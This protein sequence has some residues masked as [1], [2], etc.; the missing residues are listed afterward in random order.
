MDIARFSIDKPVN[1]WLM[2]VIL[3]LGGI[4][5]MTEIGRLEDPAF[6]IKQVKVFTAYPGAGAQKVER[7]ITEPLEIAIQQM[8]QLKKLKSTSSPGKSEIT[9]EVKSNFDSNELPQIWDELRKRLRDVATS[10]PAGS[11]DPVVFD[12]FGDVYGLYYALSAPDFDTRELR[13]FARVIRRELLTTQG[14]A[15]VTVTGVQKERIVAYINP[16]QLAGLGISF[17]DLAQLFQDNLRPFNGGRIKI[18][19]KNVRLIVERAPDRLEEISNLSLV[20]PGTNRSLRVADVATLK[21]EPADI[22]PVLIRYNGS[23]ALTLAVSALSDVNIVDVGNRVNAK[24]NA[25]LETLP[26]GIELTPIYDQASVVD[27]SV[28]GFIANLVM[29]VAVVTLTLC[30]FMGWR[31]GV[32]VGMVLLVTVMGT[33]LIMWLMNIQLQRISL[34]AMVIAM[35]MLVDNAIVVAEGMMLRMA[36]GNSAKDSASFIVKR[37]QWPLLGATVIGIAAFSGIGLSDDATG[38]FLYSLFAVVLVSLIMSW[39]L[40]VTLVPVLGNYFYKKGVKQ[41]DD[42]KPSAMQRWFTSILTGALKLRWVTIAGLLVITVVAYGSFGYVKQGFF[43]PSN[44]PL[45][46]VH[47]WGPQDRDIRATE[48]KAKETEQRLLALDNVTAVSTFI[49]QGADRFTLTYAPKSA[50][51]NYAF[52][53]VR[54]NTLDNV[55]AVQ[56]QLANGLEDIDL[57]ANFYMERMQFGPGSGAKLEAR[58]AGPDTEVLRRLADQAKQILFDDGNIKDI[59]HNWR[60]KG[61]AINTLYDNYNAGIAG[62][63]HSDFS[64]TVQYASS[65]LKLGTVQDGD[66]AY[67]IVAKMGNSTDGELQALRDSQVWS[68]QQRQYV[69]FAQVSKGLESLPEELRIQRKDRLR[70]ITVEAEPGDNETA[71]KALERIRPLIEDMPL[72]PGYSLEWGGEFESSS[73]A[74]KALGKGLPAGFLVMFIISVL[75]FGHARQ[76]LIIWLV[77]PMAIVGVVT[78]LLLTDMPFGF[79]SLLG[80]LSLFGMLIKNAIVL[81][82]E[83]DLQI[84]EGIEISNA[85]VEATLSRLRPVALA[86][87]TTILGMAPLL[88][89]AFFADMAVTI[90][91]GLTFATIL[92]LIAVPVLYSILF[93]VSYR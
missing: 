82:E 5:A 61:F 22:Q 52:F 68:S 3:L 46:F 72:P 81:I 9:V 83:I 31:S 84:E 85:I 86:A 71:A 21:L 49:G 79:M 36:T 74:Q 34:G 76:P 89:D 93:R 50:N 48:E 59:R 45:F 6:T 26:V 43:P 67:D 33:I 64:Q 87:V 12:D 42:D 75:L 41:S 32:V 13:E 60:E 54:V 39:V 65:G 20:I 27:E 63:S 2:V 11:G 44:A 35:G 10:L 18:D 77:V 23:E 90:M 14:V 58:F 73:D 80:F 66:Y 78:G 15:K 19:E 57:D 7:E 37:T 51:E 88:F 25:L 56:K 30:L 62:V 4:I 8:S 53:M 29:S 69:P 40:A 17:P 16:Y 91:G 92:T 1:V 70:T 28:D 55:S 38:E 24:V 47:Y